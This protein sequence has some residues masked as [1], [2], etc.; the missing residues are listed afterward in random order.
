VETDR[1]GLVAG[2]VGQTALKTKETVRRALNGMLFID[3]AYSLVQA[4]GSGSD[5]GQEAID[6]LV[7]EMDDR[8]DQLVVILAGY[9]QEMDGFLS[10]NPGLRSRFPTVIEFPDYTADDLAQIASGMFESG[11]FHLTAAAAAKVRAVLEEARAEP[12][13]GNGRY[14]RNLFE[15]AVRNQAVRLQ[16]LGRLDRDALETVEEED[17]QRV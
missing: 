8:R 9:S 5:F 4:A 6:T 3:E 7:K 1:S 15:K 16:Q 12:H 11:G 2:Y 17:I 13:F 10:A 14:V